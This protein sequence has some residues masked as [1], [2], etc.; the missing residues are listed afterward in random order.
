MRGICHIRR[1]LPPAT[2]L[3]VAALALA[4]AA[5]AAAEQGGASPGEASPGSIQVP[6]EGGGTYTR[7]APARLATML[8]DTPGLLLVNVH[9]PYAGEIEGTDAFIPYDQVASRVDE[10]PADK[11]APLVVYCRSG[12]MSTIAAE[13]LVRLGYTRILELDGG[14]DAWRSAGYPLRQA[15]RGGG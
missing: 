3:L 7:L 6:V 14:F 12:R 2:V 4:L 15:P 8:A 10:L 1:P 5:C 13:T 11:D 9:V